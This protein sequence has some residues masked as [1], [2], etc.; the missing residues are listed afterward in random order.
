MIHCINLFV[1]TDL[2]S[3]IRTSAQNPEDKRGPCFSSPVVDV[4]PPFLFTVE[5]HCV[6]ALM[7][8]SAGLH[9]LQAMEQLISFHKSSLHVLTQKWILDFKRSMYLK[10]HLRRGKAVPATSK[11]RCL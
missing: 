9:F 2:P 11:S 1:L 5:F 4:H 10:C 7:D 8:T 6:G 3:V